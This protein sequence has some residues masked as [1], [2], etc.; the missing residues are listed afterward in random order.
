M[1]S[2]TD[3]EL[4][5]GLLRV[6]YAD[7]VRKYQ[8]L[9]QR[10]DRRVAQDPA[11]YRLGAF[12][13]R[14]SGAALAMVDKGKI[15]LSNARFAEL[16]RS[17]KGQLVA[18]D[19][20][21]EE[22]RARAPDLRQLVIANS[23]EM[24]RLQIDADETVYRDLGSEALI[25]LRLERGTHGGRPVVLVVAEK[26]SEQPGDDRKLSRTQEALLHRERLRVL[27]E[28]AASIAH[29]LGNT[30]RG[31]SYQLAAL[32]G[33][34]TAQGDGLDTVRAVEQ[35]IE[36][37]SETVGR[38][39][40]F[41]RTGSLGVT[42]VRLDRVVTLAAALVDIEFRDS[43]PR[44]E[45]RISIPE[46]PPVRG[47][48]AELSLLF[49]NLLRN[50]REAM[51]EGGTVTVTARQTA[52]AVVVS[53]ADQGRGFPASVRTR[54]FH[55]FVST[56]GPQGTGLG[57]WL[58]AGTMRRLG[59]S[60]SAENRPHGGAVV[61]LTFP[62]QKVNRAAHPSVGRQASARRGSSARAFP[63]TGRARRNGRK[64]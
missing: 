7:L 25:S 33:S 8:E 23:E 60:I 2:N 20:E 11:I 53:V 32:R 34:K 47:S 24:L 18:L 35:R 42:A 41:A 22:E 36:V 4:P 21:A 61:V 26:V 12:G 15:E 49:V 54:L 3:D 13:M 39:H 9:V 56:K 16:A 58:A 52:Q 17:T 29:D 1:A 55:P 10:L 57:L 31:A 6:K 14:I 50:A 43:T 51:V 38:L 40:D 63:R 48:V 46:L 27:G 37:A 44:I 45:V 64:T 5:I 30:L 19:Q 59:G 62:L 28:L